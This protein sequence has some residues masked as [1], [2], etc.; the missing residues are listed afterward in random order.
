ML[1]RIAVGLALSV[2][3]FVNPAVAGTSA[4]LVPESTVLG[5]CAPPRGPGDNGVH[6]TSLR[7]E[8]I[9]CSI[10]RAV[11]LACTRF[12][13]GH[14]GICRSTGYRWHCTSTHPPN[15]TSAQRCVAGTRLMSIVWTD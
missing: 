15:M 12:T 2:L 13:Y 9:S 10:G 5:R 3:V 7:V 11:A 14:S 4:S 6:S 8:N 1:V